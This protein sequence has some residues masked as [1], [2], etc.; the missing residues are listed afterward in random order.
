MTPQ[1]FRR[2][3][4]ALDRRQPDL[5]VLLD[6]VH[7]PH[8]LSAIVRTCDAVGCLEAH[9]V[10]PEPRLAL[11]HL[12]AGGSARWVRVRRHASLAEALAALRGQGLRVL[13]AHRS[14]R[15]RDFRELDYTVPVAFLLG[16]ELEGLSGAALA[17]A[18]GEVAIPI[19]GLVESLNVS[20]AAAVL[21][22]EAERQRRR[23]GLYRRPRLDPERYQRLLFEW[24][25]P[26]IA[27][28]CRRRA[29]PYP[30]L[31]EDGEIRGP[32]SG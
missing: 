5:T 7:K 12:T 27:E 2:L 21:L 17:A 1:R 26:R 14:P 32:L 20:V 16:A 3:R 6:N 18:D 19:H 11:H 13:A 9:A 24:A 31:D 15:A 23:A 4:A 28:Y 30:E 29:L 25:H 8:N 10:W 22:F